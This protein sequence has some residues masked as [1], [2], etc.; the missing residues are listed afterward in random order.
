MQTIFLIVMFILGAC[1]GSFLC[2]QARRLRLKETSAT[3]SK[4]KL[5]PR[6]VCLSCNYQ[7]R[8]YETL[9]IISWLA[10]KGKCKKCGHKIGILELLSELGLASSFLALSTTINITSA[11]PLAWATFI[12]TLVLTLS[13]GFLTIYDGAYGELPSLCLTI[14]IIC[15]IIILILK[16]WTI[17]SIHSFSSTI[18]TDPLLSAFILGG[19]YL[20][21][22]LISKGK[23]VGDGDWL[24]ALAIGLALVHPFL[25]LIALFISNFLACVI[26]YPFVKG[27]KQKKIHLGPFLV[28]AFVI[29]ATLSNYLMAM[30]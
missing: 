11:T 13:L 28:A 27:K 20:G 26:M 9:P 10:Q 23:W 19:L 17:L 25:A 22:Y 18:I 29:T 16:E 7:L 14:S 3:R 8:W 21:L 1:M 4:K 2:C 12:M 30:L 15:A 24:L 5:G 6:S